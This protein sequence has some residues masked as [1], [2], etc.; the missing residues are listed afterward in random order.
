MPKKAPQGFPG[1]A[2]QVGKKVPII[3]KIPAP[4]QVG[5]GLGALCALIRREYDNVR[6][7]R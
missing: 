2:A 4:G 6:F 3:L 5:A 7:K 1:A